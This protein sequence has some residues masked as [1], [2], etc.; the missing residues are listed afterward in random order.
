[1]NPNK[2]SPRPCLIASFLVAFLTIG[3]VVLKSM[4]IIIP[5]TEWYQWAIIIGIA[6]SLFF[7]WLGLFIRRTNKESEETGT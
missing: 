4:Q 1:M 7:L 5:S 6:V 2:I 3:I